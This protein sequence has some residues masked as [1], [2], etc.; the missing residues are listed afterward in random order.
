M[1][2]NSVGYLNLASGCEVGSHA[3][4]GVTV[5]GSSG[6]YT[7]VLTFSEGGGG[8]GKYLVTGVQQGVGV[9]TAFE[10][11]IG[12]STS[13]AIYLYESID[14]NS[15]SINISGNSLQARHEASTSTIV[16]NVNA[17]PLCLHGN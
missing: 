13:S 11:I 4:E 14:L 7:T 2:I 5:N 9:G 10:I 15:M 17:I 12:V 8:R 1:R 16:I 3:T 6:A